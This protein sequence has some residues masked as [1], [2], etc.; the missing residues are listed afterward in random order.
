MY[1]LRRLSARKH[2]EQGI[3]VPS[4]KH[5]HSSLPRHHTRLPVAISRHNQR[6][7]QRLGSALDSSTAILRCDREHF[8]RRHSSEN[9]YDIFSQVT[10]GSAYCATLEIRGLDRGLGWNPEFLS[11][12]ERGGLP[13]SRSGWLQT[14]S[15]TWAARA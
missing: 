6:R 7:S 9:T 14:S 8:P 5:T 13:H 1:R 12:L 11:P 3:L 15:N 4:I 10:W 2:H